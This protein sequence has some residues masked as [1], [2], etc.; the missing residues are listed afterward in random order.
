MN[1]RSLTFLFLSAAL[2][3]L[4]TFNIR[5]EEPRADQAALIK[6][7]QAFTEAFEKGDAK[8]VAAFWAEDG[9]YVDL[10]DRRLQ[11]RTAIEN[12]FKDFFAENKGSKLRIDVNSVRFV[13]PETAI[14][15]GTT[16]V[17]TPDGAPPSQARYSN[18]HVKKGGQWV[19]LSVREAPYTPPGNY[20]HLRG[21]EWAIG[22]WVDEG[23]GPEVD[24]AS[25]EWALIFTPTSGAARPY[26]RWK[27][28][29]GCGCTLEIPFRCGGNNQSNHQY[30]TSTSGIKPRPN[31]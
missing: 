2:S 5:A 16:S 15:D 12:A 30:L 10:N 22:E 24:H 19:L 28:P 31:T 27:A 25:F 26:W 17:I 3:S 14:E 13:T 18:V 6:N 20:E 21:L 9:D 29:G 11:G 8:A 23:E 1:K 7:A 4:Y